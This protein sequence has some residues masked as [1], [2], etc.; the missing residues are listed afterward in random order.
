MLWYIYM[1][2]TLLTAPEIFLGLPPPLSRVRRLIHLAPRRR[3]R[4]TSHHRQARYIVKRRARHYTTYNPRTP[5][6]MGR[7]ARRRAHRH[8]RS[9]RPRAGP[10]SWAGDDV[11]RG[12]GRC[13]GFWDAGF[14]GAIDLYVF[15]DGNGCW[16]GE[17]DLRYVR[18]LGLRNYMRLGTKR[19]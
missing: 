8:W 15:L 3:I 9:L 14:G 16:L 4:T 6:H 17:L 7:H 10:D 5:G 2:L 18:R 11:F 12:A 19:L 1:D 13:G